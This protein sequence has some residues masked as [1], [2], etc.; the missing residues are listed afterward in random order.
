MYN[1]PKTV[2]PLV[3]GPYLDTFS[4]KKVIYGLD[5]LSATL[6]LTTFFLLRAD[7]F[8]YPMLLLAAVLFGSI[9]STYQVAYDSLYPNLIPEGQY[10]KAY[11]VS[12]MIYPLSA[13]MVPVAAYLY[14]TIGIAPIFLINAVTFFIAACFETQIKAAEPHT[15]DIREKYDAKRYLGDFKEGI[16]YIR[17]EKGL[18]AITAF[19]CV[20]FLCDGCTNSLFLPYFK[21][22]EG[23]SEL[24]YTYVMAFNVLGRLIGGGVHY[25]TRLPASRKYAVAVGIYILLCILTGGVLFLPMLAMMPVLFVAGLMGVTTYNIRVSSTQSYI[26]DSHRARFNGVFSMT[27]M[28]GMVLGQLISGALA[29]FMPIRAVVVLFNAV[30]L[31]AVFAI[32]VRNKDAVKK[33]YNREV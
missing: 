12:S 3:V 32:I 11:S 33:I 2:M 18:L 24:R 15:G 30:N 28:L 13:V 10:A 9:D 22:T 31:L 1:L 26:P 4:R 7:I 14:G 6:Y 25:R 20:I 27:T 16:R 19:F 5:F 8:N 21:M 23:L 17:G 29:E